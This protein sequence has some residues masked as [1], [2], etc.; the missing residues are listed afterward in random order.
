MGDVE[1]MAVT[2]I[3]EVLGYSVI[4]GASYQ[5]YICGFPQSL[6]TVLG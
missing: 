6:Q 5:N 3:W 1:W 4:S 2:L